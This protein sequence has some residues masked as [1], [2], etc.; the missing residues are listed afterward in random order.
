MHRG[1]QAAARAS[2]VGLKEGCSALGSGL[3]LADG[4]LTEALFFAA[5]TLGAWA[6]VCWRVVGEVYT[7]IYGYLGGV[8]ASPE[9]KRSRPLDLHLASSPDLG[10][11]PGPSPDHGH[12]TQP[13]STDVRG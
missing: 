10:P 5:A 9:P 3:A 2:W 1:V 4:L 11:G 7:A 12:D 13:R 8:G 6:R